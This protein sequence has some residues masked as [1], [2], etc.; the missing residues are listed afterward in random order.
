MRIHRCAAGSS[1]ILNYAIF[2]I[3]RARED[4][5]WSPR[6]TITDGVRAYVEKL[7]ELKKRAVKT[8]PKVARTR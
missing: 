7:E 5:G 6:F 3:T 8:P 1:K 4:L 2:D